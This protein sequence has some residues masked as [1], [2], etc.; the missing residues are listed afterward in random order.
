[1]IPIIRNWI[2]IAKNHGWNDWWKRS[3]PF[4]TVKQC[5]SFEPSSILF[6][7]SSA[8][9]ESL[10]TNRVSNGPLQFKI[11]FQVLPETWSKAHPP[12]KAINRNLFSTSTENSGVPLPSAKSLKATRSAN[13]NVP[14]SKLK[15][16][17]SHP[18]FVRT[19]VDECSSPQNEN[20]D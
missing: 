16:T 9:P 3:P 19:R 17:D 15:N 8:C 7:I 5:G 13:T 11:F 14:F 20:N 6:L 4:S 2:P 18:T 12:A 1:M 10:S